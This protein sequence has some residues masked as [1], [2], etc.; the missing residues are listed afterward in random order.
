[1]DLN[2]L[3]IEELEKL[4]RNVEKAIV[5]KR[6][7]LRAEAR[8]AAEEA[9]R[10]FGYSL[11][12]LLENERVS[13]KKPVKYRNPENPAQTWSGRGRMPAWMKTQIEK[14]RSREEFL[15]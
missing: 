12:D 15:A 7:R 3:S 4:R 1:M 11:K 2:A 8:K 9:A 5:A 10:K 14:G 13:G 6:A